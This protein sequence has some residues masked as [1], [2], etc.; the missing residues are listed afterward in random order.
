MD[1]TNTDFNFYDFQFNMTGTFYLA[2][3]GY[4]NNNRLNRIDL[5]SDFKFL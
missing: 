4:S 3:V 1:L 2:I 5:K